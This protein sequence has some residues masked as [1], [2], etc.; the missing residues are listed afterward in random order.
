MT[1]L[2]K[3]PD[4]LADASRL[5]VKFRSP[6]VVLAWVAIVVPIRLHLGDWS[7]WDF[8]ILLALLA[9]WPFKEWLIH[10]F[11]LHFKPVK[12]GRFT[13]DPK[14]ASKHR[15]HHRNPWQL[16]ILFIPEHTFIYGVPILALFWWTV[17]P[18]P[19]LAF[20]G[21][22]LEGLLTLHY[23]WVHYLV[24]TRYKPKSRMYERLWRNHRLHHCKNEHYWLGVTML[25]GDKVL[26]TAK[27]KDEVPT[28][29]TCMT[30]GAVEDLGQGAAG[31]AG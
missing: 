12:I 19:A 13:F 14:N 24:H 16:D 7:R 11:V 17:T 25:S 27:E 6:K 2:A 26:G 20:T 3:S 1:A 10:R 5:F 8:A 21:L 18:T 9:W 29:D 4:N 30:L 15:R 31:S 22:A 23:E 28:S